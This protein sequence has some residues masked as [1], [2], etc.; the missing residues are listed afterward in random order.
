MFVSSK[1]TAKANRQLLDPLVIL[2]GNLPNWLKEIGTAW[3]VKLQLLLSFAQ[4][5]ATF[6]CM[7]I[8]FCSVCD[9]G[10]WLCRRAPALQYDSCN[11]TTTFTYRSTY[12]FVFPV[13]L[14]TSR[15]FLSLLFSLW[16]L[17]VAQIIIYHSKDIITLG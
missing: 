11:S 3:Y 6:A 14:V 8:C 7:H 9:R 17:L 12:S 16:L 2:T 4:G 15:N 5:V 13:I 10:Q 1:L